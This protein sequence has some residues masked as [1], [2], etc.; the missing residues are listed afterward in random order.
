MAVASVSFQCASQQDVGNLCR[1]ALGFKKVLA[2]SVCGES[3]EIR[4]RYGWSAA[5]WGFRRLRDSANQGVAES[6]FFFPPG[7]FI[8]SVRRCRQTNLKVSSRQDAC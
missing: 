5:V 3:C 6:G 2:L 4:G 1:G 8:V 7:L